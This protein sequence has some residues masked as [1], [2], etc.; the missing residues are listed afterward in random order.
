M[1]LVPPVTGADQGAP[2]A[3]LFRSGEGGYD[4]YRIPALIALPDGVV[5]A[6]AEGRVGGAGDSGNIDVVMRRSED[7]GATWGPLAVVWDDAA[8]TCGNPCPVFD[9]G[10]GAVHLLLTWNHG[11]DHEGEIRAGRSRFGGRKPFHAVSRDG[12]RSW[13]PPRDL[14]ESADR[15]EWGWY[16]TGPGNGIQLARGAFAGRLVVPANH[17]TDGVYDA[18]AL[19]SDDH[20]ETWRVGRGTVATG[21]NESTVVELA[22]G[23]L[24]LN[25][26]MQT[27]GQKL[28]GIALSRDGGETWEDFRHDPNLSCPTCQ[29]AQIR[30]HDGTLVFS[31]PQG[32]GRSGLALQLSP[33]E[34]STWPKRLV[35]H[36]GPS[37]YS[38]LAEISP[39]RIGILYEASDS[40]PYHAGGIAFR[41]VDTGEFGER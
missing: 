5:L 15:P 7:G 2:L 37:A 10:A 8:N 14:S 9:A 27:H 4:T 35:V 16:A 3:H 32:G 6:F 21:A 13:S 39:G 28:R 20:G 18:H 36:G 29:A 30:L 41:V 31:N 1:W 33:D 17:S 25:T 26:R 22:D 23:T 40:G 34:G 19:L 12:G 24:L 11:E 38:S